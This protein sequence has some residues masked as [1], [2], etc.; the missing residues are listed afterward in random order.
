MTLLKQQEKE[1][2]EIWD[3]SWDLLLTQGKPLFA[4][5]LVPHGQLGD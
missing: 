4:K 5:C 2:Q 3:L 1:N